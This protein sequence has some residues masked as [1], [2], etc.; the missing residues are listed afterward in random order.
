MK[1]VGIT[2]A[3]AKAHILHAETTA[4]LVVAKRLLAETILGIDAVPGTSG[5]PKTFAVSQACCFPNLG[6][7]NKVRDWRIYMRTLRSR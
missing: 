1:D 4:G 2:Q 3:I 6:K 5:S 7:A